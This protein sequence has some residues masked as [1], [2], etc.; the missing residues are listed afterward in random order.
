[1]AQRHTRKRRATAGR[2]A[3]TTRRAPANGA[4]LHA[5]YRLPDSALERAL[6]S[7]EQGSVIESYFG[8]DSYQELCALA[9]Q[10]ASKS[11]RGGPRVLILPG[12]M[13]S[14][15]GTPGK[16]FDDVIWIDPISIGAGRLVDLSLA[17]G[18][19]KHQ[20][21]GVVLFAYLKL[22]LR[23]KLS[24][25]DADFYPFDWR[26]SLDQL[27]DD[28][29]K[30]LKDEAPE[31]SLVAHSMGGLVARAA[32]ARKAP[33]VKRLIMLG[34]PN[35]GSF[36]P[37]QAIRGTYSVVRDVAALDQRHDAAELAELIFNS[38]P[39]LYQMLPQPA[40]YTA[41]DLTD[42]SVWPKGGPQPNAALLKDVKRIGNSLAKADERFVLIAGVNQ[43]TIT[44]VKL[45]GAEFVYEQS[46][47]GDGTVPLALARLEN[48]KTY[49]V[50]ESHGSLPNNGVVERAVIDLLTTGATSA[51]PDQWSPTR[52]GGV[53]LL[54]E[55]AFPQPAKRRSGEASASDVRRLLND[56][57]SPDARDDTVSSAPSGATS[58]GGVPAGV[59]D[60]VVVGRRR[61]HR[62]DLKL[63]L[64]GIADVEADAYLLGMFRDVAPS[65]AARDLDMRLDGA[66]TEFTNR[67]MFNANVGEIFVVPTGRHLVRA[68]IVVF[69]GLGPFDH[70]DDG[71][72]RLAAENAVR[73]FIQTNV[74]D[75][76]TVLLGAGSGRDT[77]SS[78]ENLLAG[79][80]RGVRDADR[81]HRMRSL[82]LCEM[83]PATYDVIKREVFRL[84]GTSLFE[85]VEV[86]LSEI[87]MPA[88]STPPTSTRRAEPGSDPVYLIVREEK[89]EK[90]SSTFRSSILTAGA[91]ASVIS[92]SKE[93]S[94]SDLD[95]QIASITPQTFT[96]AKLKT[97]GSAL[98]QLVLAERVADVLPT[99]KDRHL[100]VVH[101]SGASQIPWETILLKDWYPAANAGLSRRYMAENLSIAKWLEQ[102]ADGKTLNI[103]LVVNPTGDL[104]GA[105]QEG[106][107]LRKLFGSHP[108]ISLTQRH[109]EQAT[110][111]T[112]LGDFRSGKY[113]VVHYAGHA[114][115]D[116]DHPAQS[117]IRCHQG[118]VLSG[119][120]LAG[121]GR[122]PAL[123]FFNA[124]EAGRIRGSVNP[125]AKPPS[126]ATRIQHNVG[127]AEA[128]LR[129]GVANYVGTYWPVGDAAADAF[130][131]TFY[132]EL[133]NGKS[134]GA[135]LCSG[136]TAVLKLKSADWADYIHYGSFD[137]V[138]RKG[139]GG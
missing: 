119:A 64:G 86:T 31:V 65:G 118:K 10:A 97:L 19:T 28:L 120:D 13:G 61:Q 3:Q 106:E 76:A 50:E 127:L 66:I 124:C 89:R 116:P 109:A 78:L 100:V 26:Q 91:K 135:A 7:G 75:F 93:A 87:E 117:G 42:P 9:K 4:G 80:V 128:F 104:T 20:P 11:V 83:D 46:F 115:F 41:V 63:A 54:R 40:K 111:E 44:G 138:M 71:V 85:D 110:K 133:L 84:S 126:V 59:L 130:A 101:D 129:G 139:S 103:L 35:F 43:D 57:A 58:T 39:G 132:S 30:S 55:S 1:M 37:V 131:N 113:D 2:R 25:F 96:P 69:V 114:F 47:E 105:E 72:Q 32:L 134:I 137:F 62:I 122:L 56:L 14:K 49:Y 51:L 52:R 99:M 79:F 136:R 123:V 82:T 81:Q 22:K 45:D 121:V 17:H 112:L 67:R 29:S 34:T 12:I 6:L 38:F 94:R 98:A 15:L 53:R 24:G 8:E 70:F 102:R 16:L 73:T 68:D 33:N 36:A 88:P 92:E 90:G 21:L 27:G 108:A 95:E 5:G 48:A 18:P 125:K 107:R 77:A 74:G 23:L 60:Q